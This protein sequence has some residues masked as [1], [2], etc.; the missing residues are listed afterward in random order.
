MPGIRHIVKNSADFVKF[1]TTQSAVPRERVA[2][3]GVKDHFMSGSAERLSTH[4]SAVI[5]NTEERV[6]AC[7]LLKLS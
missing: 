1:F 5:R 4:A 7:L 3:L 6:L 2:K